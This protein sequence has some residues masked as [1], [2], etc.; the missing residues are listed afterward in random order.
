MPETSS[1]SLE[2][3]DQSTVPDV[4]IEENVATGGNDHDQKHKQ[5]RRSRKELDT[6]GSLP[7]EITEAPHV[8]FQLGEQEE[9]KQPPAFVE[10]D[11][12]SNGE[13]REVASY[14]YL[15]AF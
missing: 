11:E 7:L 9:P 12:L 2:K 5:S 14:Q 4:V 1:P 10:L 8:M 6:S 3:S 13:W 15:F